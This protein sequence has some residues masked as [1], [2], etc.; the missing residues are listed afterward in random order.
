MIHARIAVIV[1]L[2]CSAFASGARADTVVLRSAASVPTARGITLGD[3]A[4]LRGKAAEALAGVAVSA[5]PPG[6]GAELRLSVE[7]VRR[8]IGQ[9]GLANW[10][11]ISLSGAACVVRRDDA[12]PTPSL[13]APASAPTTRNNGPSVRDAITER[14][15]QAFDVAAED[16]RLS[17]EDSAAGLLSTPTTGRTVIVQPTGSSDRVPVSVRVFEGERLVA[18]GATRVKVEVRRRV[19]TSRGLILRGATITH[20]DLLA[21]EQWLPPTERPAT[22]EEAVGSVARGRI[23]PGQRIDAGDLTPPIAIRRGD[24]VSVTCL[25][26]SVTLKTTARALSDGTVGE[27]I[28]FE[29]AD[30]R[31]G[32]TGVRREPNRESEREQPKPIRAR[33]DGPGRA[34]VLAAGASGEIPSVPEA[35]DAAPKEDGR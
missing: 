8:A 19:V 26:G 28:E 13:P 6:G 31:R 14:L 7:D 35:G 5:W 17:F 15:G 2:G 1:I 11:L 25:A 12:A 34:V 21:D 22:L 29:R 24:I 4:E 16:L 30:A 9:S 33:V 23:A 10:G 20:A 27:V 3:V 32:A 18:S